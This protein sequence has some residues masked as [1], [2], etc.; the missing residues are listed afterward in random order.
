ML[1]IKLALPAVFWTVILTTREKD[2]SIPVLIILFSVFTLVMVVWSII[3]ICSD[4]Y[5]ESSPEGFLA[6]SWIGSRFVQWS[7]VHQVTIKDSSEA[8]ILD[9]D[10]GRFRLPSTDD[11][12]AHNLTVAVWQHLRRHGKEHGFE[13]SPTAETFWNPLPEDSPAQVEWINKK[14]YFRTSTPVFH[15]MPVLPILVN[16]IYLYTRNRILTAWLFLNVATIALLIFVL[17]RDLR[18]YPKR[19]VTSDFG[20]LI[21]TGFGSFELPWSVVEFVNWNLGGLRLDSGRKTVVIPIRKGEPE[22]LQLFLSI[23][24]HLRC[25]E[26]PIHIPL[27]TADEE[28]LDNFELTADS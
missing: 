5:W 15:A 9:T 2:P 10:K 13:L 8:Y 14:P 6:V 1:A 26:N 20:L 11:I 22:N 17:V 3:Q 4:F 7:E 24:K 18:G 16:V 28:P 21:E 12:S 27:T 25:R 23:V 19:V